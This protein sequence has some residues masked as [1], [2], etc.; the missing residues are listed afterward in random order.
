MKNFFLIASL[1]IAGFI[2]SGCGSVTRGTSETVKVYASPEDAQIAT[3]IGMSCP[4]SPCTLK[5]PR[6]TEFAVTVSKEGYKTEKVNVSTEVAGTGVASMAG[7]VLVGGII[8]AGVDAYTGAMLNHNPNPVLVEL[9]PEN[10]ENPET[11]VGD[12]SQVKQRYAD[13]QKSHQDNVMERG[14]GV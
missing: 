4:S 7:N 5:V 9:K 10:P 11:P 6:K 14:G 13:L 8:G 3:N 12:L 2:L 1:L